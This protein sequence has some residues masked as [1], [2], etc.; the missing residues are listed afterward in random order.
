MKALPW[1]V[2]GIK[3]DEEWTMRLNRF[4]RDGQA[5]LG[6]V[7]VASALLGAVTAVGFAGTAQAIPAQHLAITVA[8]ASSDASGAALSPQPQITLED[9]SDAAVTGQADVITASFT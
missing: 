7:V 3:S 5:R 8:P 4:F 2:R 1:N 6:R 9:A